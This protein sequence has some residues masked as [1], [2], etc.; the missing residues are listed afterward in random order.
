MKTREK[1]GDLLGVHIAGFALPDLQEYLLHHALGKL[2]RFQHPQR[3]GIDF[4]HVPMVQQCKS[5]S[6]NLIQGFIIWVILHR[7]LRLNLFIAEMKKVPEHVEGCGATGWFNELTDS[8]EGFVGVPSGKVD[9]EV[10]KSV[11]EP[12][13]IAKEK[14]LQQLIALTSTLNGLE[15]A[16]IEGVAA[17]NQKVDQ[18]H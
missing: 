5:I 6:K 2:H 14:T 12:T 11:L 4:P 1:S 3:D 18:I 10:E 17:V 16:G 15:M 13:R 7:L 8:Q 9:E